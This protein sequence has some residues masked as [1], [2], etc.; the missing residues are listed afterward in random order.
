MIKRIRE[1]EKLSR[2]LDPEMGQRDKWNLEVLDYTN[3]FTHS[4]I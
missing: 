4:P 2:L 3:T 1:L